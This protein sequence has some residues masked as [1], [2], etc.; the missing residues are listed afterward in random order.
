[1]ASHTTD[2][3]P[4]RISDE[5]RKGYEA[6]EWSDP[7]PFHGAQGVSGRGQLPDPN[8]CTCDKKCCSNGGFVSGCAGKCLCNGDDCEGGCPCTKE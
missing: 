3:V 4:G 7:C 6:V 5:Y 2:W 1:M 8:D